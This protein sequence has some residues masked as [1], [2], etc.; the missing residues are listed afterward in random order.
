MILYI[1]FF[2]CVVITIIFDFSFA[3]TV[4]LIK[5]DLFNFFAIKMA[6]N[7]Y[8]QT[9]GLVFVTILPRTNAKLSAVQVLV[10]RDTR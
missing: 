2:H 9:H 6:S 1:Y 8:N 10:R 7:M 5:N 4:S 3:L